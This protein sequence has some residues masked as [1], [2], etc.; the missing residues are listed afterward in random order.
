M[1]PDTGTEARLLSRDLLLAVAERL[2]D[3][4]SL[5][6]LELFERLVVLEE[7]I[8]SVGA[9]FS[10]SPDAVYA[11]KSRLGKVARALA[12]ELSPPS[13]SELLAV[14]RRSEKAP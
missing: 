12:I 11:W 1:V 7:S 10:L 9:A 6:G 3:K 2:R 5:R 8:D 14:S 4:L 13:S